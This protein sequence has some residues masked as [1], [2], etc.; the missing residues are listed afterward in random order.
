MDEAKCRTC[1]AEIYFV[2]MKESAKLIPVNR[3]PVRMIRVTYTG[4]P[5]REEGQMVSV[6]QSHFATCPQAKDWGK[7]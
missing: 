1:G 5:Q 3:E 2:P 4:Y 7:D 6:Y